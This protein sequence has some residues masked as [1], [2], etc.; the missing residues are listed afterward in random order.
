[1]RVVII[2]LFTALAISFVA[3]M[4]CKYLIYRN[5]KVLE[6]RLMILDICAE[7]LNNHTD[8]KIND[9]DRFANKYT[10]RQLLYSIKPLKLK[11][12]YTK[13]ELDKILN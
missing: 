8:S 7:Y 13:E 6:F 2:I 10:D 5:E 1:M 12:W 3:L 4:V 11:Y 9:V